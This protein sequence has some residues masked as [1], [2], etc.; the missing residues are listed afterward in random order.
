MKFSGRAPTEAP[1]AILPKPLTRHMHPDRA[2]KTGG[3][4]PRSP[5]D[6]AALARNGVGLGGGGAENGWHTSF[7]R[8]VNRSARGLRVR[9]QGPLDVHGL[10]RSDSCAYRFPRAAELSLSTAKMSTSGWRTNSSI[11]PTTCRIPK[12]FRR[13]CG[14]RDAA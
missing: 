1:S 8:K 11:D 7:C 3:A 4:S 13:D 5:S 14:R 2:H 6:S 12:V 10:P 9:S